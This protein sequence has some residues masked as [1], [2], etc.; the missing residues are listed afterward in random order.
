V[1]EEEF[2]VV[3][4]FPDGSTK[5]VRCGVEE[6][7]LDAARRYGLGLPSSCEQGWDLACAVRV[8]SGS[9]DNS[10]A[11]RYYEEDLRARFALICTASPRSN[12]R[13]RTHQ[14]K[15]M[16]RHR[17]EHGLPAPRGNWGERE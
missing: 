1:V 7:I 8:L 5:V 3:F 4:E 14:R 12:M 15:E 2:E 6:H 16:Q 10:D 11:R 9:W 13:V 17:R